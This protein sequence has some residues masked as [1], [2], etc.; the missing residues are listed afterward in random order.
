ME[1]NGHTIREMRLKLGLTVVDACRASGI[2]EST[3]LSWESHG[4]KGRRPSTTRAIDFLRQVAETRIIE[5]EKDLAAY[6]EWLK[7]L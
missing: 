5:K 1:N 3:W 4:K 7:S 6:R 2:P